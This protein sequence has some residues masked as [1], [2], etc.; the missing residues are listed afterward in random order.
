MTTKKELVDYWESSGNITHKEILS[1]FHAIER[2][3]FVSEELKPHAYEDRALP[4]GF[5]QT[6]S[7]PTTVLFM[8]Q[9]LDPKKDNIVLEIGAGSGYNAALL[10]K[11][12]KKVYAVEIKEEVLAL[13]KKNLAKIKNVELIHADGSKG[14]KE[15]APFDRIIIAAACPEVPHHLI[16][17]L[18]DQGILVAPVG[19]GYT[20]ELI[21]ITKH[22]KHI[23]EEGLGFFS[24]VPLTGERGVK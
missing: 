1:A 18:A 2:K 16:E 10:A 7:Q 19:E 8:L 22:G 13:A 17:Q 6:I 24:F 12:C 23:R 9:A 3:D 15:K 5:G 14:L 21:K 4:I 11:L 20:Q